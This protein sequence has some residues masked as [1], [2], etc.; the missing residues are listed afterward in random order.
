MKSSGNSQSP[1]AHPP[2][3]CVQRERIAQA[4]STFQLVLGTILFAFGSIFLA[5][6]IE[7]LINKIN[8]VDWL[9]ARWY[10]H[11]G[12]IFVIL[13]GC[14]ASIMDSNLSWQQLRA[15]SSPLNGT[16]FDPRPPYA[17]SGV[18]FGGNIVGQRTVTCDRNG[19]VI[20]RRG[21]P[22]VY[23]PWKRLAKITIQ[24]DAS[25]PLFADVQLEW[26]VPGKPPEMLIPWS[27]AMSANVPTDM[28]LLSGAR[29]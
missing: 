28:N 2:F 29:E 7:F 8:F 20:W 23:F 4:I 24:G 5:W 12:I 6:L 15:L 21:L 26:R 11:L 3:E 13:Y 10:V 25:Q 1:A 9:I 16:T 27:R 14:I 19:L 18:I 17:T 22:Q